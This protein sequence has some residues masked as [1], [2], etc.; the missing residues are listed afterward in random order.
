MLEVD[1]SDGSVL[2]FWQI[3]RETTNGTGTSDFSFRYF[4][5]SSTNTVFRLTTAG[6]L[7]IDGSLNPTSD[8]NAKEAFE[9]ID[10]REILDRVIA[11][12]LN[13]WQ[14]IDDKDETRHIGPFAQDFYAA[15]DVGYDDKSIS[16]TDADGVAL[17][18]I[19]GL[20]Q[21]VESENAILR[22]ENA[23]L[24]RRLEKLES[25]VSELTNNQGD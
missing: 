9:T 24:R 8:R 14:F 12:P 16:T 18:A 23:E 20:N 19:Q 7:F 3:I 22:Q 2:D 1:S 21:K 6:D 4:N 15:F 13:T 17:A 11:L 5:G 10:P 25:M